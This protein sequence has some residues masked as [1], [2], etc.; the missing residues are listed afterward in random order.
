MKEKIIKDIREHWTKKAED[1]LLG[2]QIVKVEYM[3][4]EE[5]KDMMWYN[6][7]LCILLENPKGEKFWIYPS[8][9]DEGNDGGALFTTIK[10][11]PCAP[12]I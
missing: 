2:C 6:S 11:Y 12:V 10:G 1:N 9:D 4:D 3:P 7:P 5:V 8:R